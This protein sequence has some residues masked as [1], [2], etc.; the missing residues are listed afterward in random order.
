MW[1]E[2][3]GRGERKEERVQWGGKGGLR[4][5]AA[6]TAR[7]QGDQLTPNIMGSRARA[8][9]EIGG[10]YMV[11]RRH[12]I[13]VVAGCIRPSLD[14]PVDGRQ[15]PVPCSLPQAQLRIGPRVVVWRAA[16]E[17]QRWRGP[18]CRARGAAA[19]AT[20][21]SSRRRAER[22]HAAAQKQQHGQGKAPPG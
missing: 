15:I 16:V 20:G 18:G 2:G 5:D 10:H 14:G 3:R 17:P 6:G 1:R 9:G 13:R 19:P 8:R 12:L 22:G 11:E 4:G 7:C 21:G